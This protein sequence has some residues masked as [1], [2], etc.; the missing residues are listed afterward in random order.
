MADS[1][2]AEIWDE[3]LSR[4]VS[5]ANAQEKSKLMGGLSAIQDEQIL[6]DFIQLGKNE[7]IIRQQDYF[8]MLSSVANNRLGEQLVWDFYR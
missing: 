2:T 1:G 8:S 6:A 3:M 4:Y 7:S 5:E